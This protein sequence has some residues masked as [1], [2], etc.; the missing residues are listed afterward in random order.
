MRLLAR[1]LF[2]RARAN[3]IYRF[4]YNK[5]RP[6]SSE[7]RMRPGPCALLSLPRRAHPLRAAFPPKQTFVRQAKLMR[8]FAFLHESNA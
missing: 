4:S 8:K 5:P 2:N 7:G 1:A 6:L 3:P